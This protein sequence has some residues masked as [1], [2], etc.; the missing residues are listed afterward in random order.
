VTGTNL[1]MG[2]LSR[3]N[4]DPSDWTA[5]EESFFAAAPPEIAVQPPPAASFED[6]APIVSDR[7]RRRAARPAP[8]RV[9]AQARAVLSRVVAATRGLGAL[10]LR[11]VPRMAPAWAGLERDLRGLASRLASELPERPDGKTLAAALAA[12]V[13]VFGVSAKV[14]GSRIAGTTAPAAVAAA[15]QRPLP[16]LARAEPSEQA[17]EIAPEPAREAPQRSHPPQRSLVRPSATHRHPKHH[18]GPRAKSAPRARV[19]AR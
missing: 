7:P 1:D 4:V 2:Q 19:R 9:V 16:P 14:L 12:L 11:L 10:T 8:S 18:A 17:P 15:A 5:L 6:L 3:S 13:V